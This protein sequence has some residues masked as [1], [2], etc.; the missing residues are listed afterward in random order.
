MN[1]AT[2]LPP[3]P[4][5]GAHIRLCISFAAYRVNNNTVIQGNKLCPLGAINL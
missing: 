2:H 4:W 1:P 5:F 3:I